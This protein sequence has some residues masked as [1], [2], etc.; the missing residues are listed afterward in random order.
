M[1]FVPNSVSLSVPIDELTLVAWINAPSW[2]LVGCTTFAPVFMKSNTSDNA[3]QYRMSVGSN[4]MGFAKNNWN[5]STGSSVSISF[6]EWYLMIITFNNG[7]VKGYLNGV[8]VETSTVTG[9][10]NPNNLP[11]EIGRE[12][13]GITEVFHGKLDDLRIY[14]R[15]FN[16][17]EA[18]ELFNPNDIIFADDFE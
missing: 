9:P 4:G 13:P 18:W 7:T 15:E 17:Y 10:I 6:N 12:V 5:N 16:K 8:L 2:S 1:I 14:S 11:L 3:F